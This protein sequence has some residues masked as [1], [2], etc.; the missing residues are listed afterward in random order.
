MLD[1][2]GKDTILYEFT[3]GPDG[4]GPQTGVIVDLAGN[5]N[6]TTA[7]GGDLSCNNGYGCG[8]IYKLSP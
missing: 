8:T 7:L 4:E 5:I 2:T 1:P 3:G 6:G